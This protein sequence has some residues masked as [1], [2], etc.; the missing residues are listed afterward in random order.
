MFTR[1]MQSLVVAMSVGLPG[2][3]AVRGEEP[4]IVGACTHFAQAKG[5]PPKNLQMMVDVGVRSLRDEVYW[6]G[7]ER[8]KGKLEMPE[9]WDRYI[10]MSA[11]MGVR[12]LMLLGYGNA[13][14]DGGGKPVSEE[15]RA[16][17]V[18]YSQF[19][20]DRF[21]GQIPYY[22]VWNEWDIGIGTAGRVPGLPGDYVRLLS[23]VYPAIKAI[24]PEAMVM[25]TGVTPTAI[26]DDWFER[27]LAAG[28]LGHCD[29]V[30][31]HTY[32]YDW[33]DQ[34]PEAL[35]D[36]VHKAIRLVRQYNN[37]QDKPIYI[38]EGGW[39]THEGL[40]SSTVEAQASY[41]ARFYLLLQATPEVRGFWWYDF[42]DDGWKRDDPEDNFGVVRPDLTAKPAYHVLRDVSKFLKTAR[43]LERVE[44]WTPDLYVLRFRDG[45]DRPVM[46]IWSSHTHYNYQVVFRSRDARK[47]TVH[48]LGGPVVEQAW[49]HRDWPGQPEARPSG[50]QFSIVAANMPTL[51]YL[52]SESVEVQTIW[53]R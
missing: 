15:A 11:E 28:V 17:F 39:P 7:I 32:N 26:R 25:S 9:A 51:L 8:E 5:D 47:V 24:D 52:D 31:I 30:A 41:L 33:P 6:S 18:R 38:T 22:E 3:E 4:F 42:Q 21:K 37:G 48:T 53:R 36:V 19:V 2:V 40:Y 49:S 44:T 27:L 34:S 10:Q 50:R 29:A 16:A 14:Y 1:A 20:V 46:A 23:E 13:L 12:P 35:M 43:F 45:E